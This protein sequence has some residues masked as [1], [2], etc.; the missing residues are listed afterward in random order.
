MPP[1]RRACRSAGLLCWGSSCGAALEQREEGA[2]QLAEGSEDVVSRLQE[3]VLE[4]QRGAG[5]LWMPGDQGVTGML[6]QAL[7]VH[8]EAWLRLGSV[9]LSVQPP[10]GM[11]DV[12]GHKE[13][14]ERALLSPL[15]V[16]LCVSL[17][18]HRACCWDLHSLASFMRLAGTS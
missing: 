15:A 5:K 13:R 12:E 8:R 11:S 4:A 7:R 2:Q 6:L 1:T 10:E 18:P 3:H 17:P 9:G 16:P 14:M